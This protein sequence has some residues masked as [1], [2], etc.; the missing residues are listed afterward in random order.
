MARAKYPSELN[1]K[2]VRVSLDDYA[3]LKYI[4]E[5]AHITMAEALHVALDISWVSQFQQVA[6]IKP[7]SLQQAEH[8][9]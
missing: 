9:D 2:Q 7:P 5:K 1:N 6:A 3:L 8:D 4:S